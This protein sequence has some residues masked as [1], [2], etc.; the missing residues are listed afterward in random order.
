MPGDEPS[1]GGH[2]FDRQPALV[3]RAAQPAPARQELT[4]DRP[5]GRGVRLQ[6]GVREPRPGRGQS[7]HRRRHDHFPGLVAGRLRPLR[8]PVHPHGLAQCR[9]VPDPRRARWGGLG[10]AA[11]R[12]A[13]QLAR[14]RQ[15]RQG[16]PLALAGQGEVRAQDLLGRPHDLGRE[17]RARVHGVRDLRLRGR[18]HRRLG[19]RRGHLL[20]SRGHLAR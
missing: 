20:G 7:R 1:P 17:L 16:P 10:H 12:P 9:D 6:G 4:A 3:A 15:P 14:Q 5:D 18:A 11:L 19:T 8:A 13:Q 2:R